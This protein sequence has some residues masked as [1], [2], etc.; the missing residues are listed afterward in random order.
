MIIFFIILMTVFFLITTGP[1]LYIDTLSDAQMRE[2]GVL[3]S[4][5]V[6]AEEDDSDDDIAMATP[7]LLSDPN[8]LEFLSISE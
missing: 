6:D 2:A 4:Y 1:S 8:N 7:L 5:K 3:T